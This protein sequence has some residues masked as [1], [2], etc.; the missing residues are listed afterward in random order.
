[1]EIVFGIAST[2]QEFN[3]I[4]HLQ[5]QNL[6]T[7]VTEDEQAK[8]GFVFVEHT[9]PLL[10][11]MASYL[12]QVIAV[13]NGQ[14]VG[15]NLAMHIAMRAE[16][17]SLIPMFNIFDETSYRD[18]PLNTYSF[19]MGGQVCVDKAFR[20]QGLLKKLYE[21]TRDCLP[22]DYQLC[23]TEVAARNTVS[24]NAHFKMGFEEVK[25]YSDGKELWKV[26]AWDLD[27]LSSSQ[28][29]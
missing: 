28:S 10:E 5:R 9:L 1:M 27:P 16:I 23:V 29:A 7:K 11:K 14:V 13:C 8:H 25:T 6:Y 3:Q 15:Y 24:L 19:I 21:E 18:K 17:P 12:P 2:P 20:G 4:L 26:I 22:P